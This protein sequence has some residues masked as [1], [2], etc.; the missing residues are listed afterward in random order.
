MP[1]IFCCITDR[2]YL[3]FLRA[4]ALQLFDEV[5]PLDLAI[6]PLASFPKLQEVPRHCE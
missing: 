6:V 4:E 1:T 5:C 3:T 2:G